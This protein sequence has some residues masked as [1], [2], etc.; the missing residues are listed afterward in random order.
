MIFEDYEIGY[1]IAQGIGFLAMF[2]SLISFQAKT[3]GGIIA[4]Q[5]LSN[6]ILVIQYLMLGFYSEDNY[7]SAVVAN[8]IGLIRNTIYS[9]R[10][11]WRISK[12]KAVPVIAIVIFI[13]SGIFTYETPYDILPV[14]SMCVSSIAF[15]MREER[16]IRC[17]SVLVILPWVVYSI[18]A[19]N[20]A[21]MLTDGLNLISVLIAIVRFDII[22]KIRK[23]GD[24]MNS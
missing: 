2:F 13:V 8:F 3:R 4:L 14:F 23:S 24:G 1:I 11:K 16:L 20:I 15:F 18:Y 17:L 10:G 9:F 19:G 12:S 7:Y 6:S 5:I 21:S 22:A